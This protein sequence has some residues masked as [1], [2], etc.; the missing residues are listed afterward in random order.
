MASVT[1]WKWR[2]L[3]CSVCDV[4]TLVGAGYVDPVLAL[5]ADV[6]VEVPMRFVRICDYCGTLITEGRTYAIKVSQKRT[7]HEW[8]VR[9]EE[10]STWDC[11]VMYAM[12]MERE[13][14]MERAD[15]YDAAAD[16]IEVHGWT[17]SKLED[18]TTGEVCVSGAIGAVINP[19][20]IRWDVGHQSTDTEVAEW[21]QATMALREFI[22]HLDDIVGTKN[23]GPTRNPIA[24]NNRIA[25]N[26]YEVI[27]LLRRA[28]KAIRN[29]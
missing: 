10:L 12:R 4:V 24:W 20:L 13:D 9:S 26:K 19:T 22:K 5:G 25:K 14:D 29:A 3:R 15:L 16:Y 21:Q 28:A 2:F 6:L 1:H 8:D 7:V 18:T 11:V 23:F 27:D 17:V